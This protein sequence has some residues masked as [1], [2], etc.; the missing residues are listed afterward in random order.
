[1]T[2]TTTT[3]TPASSQ[4]HTGVIREK[5]HAKR[6]T[7][8]SFKGE[9]GISEQVEKSPRGGARPR[10]GKRKGTR[11]GAISVQPFTKKHGLGNKSGVHGAG[12]AMS[13]RAS[14]IRQKTWVNQTSTGYV[15]LEDLAYTLDYPAYSGD[16]Y[17]QVIRDSGRKWHPMPAE[18]LGKVRFEHNTDYITL[19][20]NGEVTMIRKCDGYIFPNANYNKNHDA[21][22]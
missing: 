15:P 4:T 2:K 22:Y 21:H 18:P 14:A 11:N 10:G 7:P 1:M 8:I 3:S 20:D 5:I 17:W 19:L 12:S 13:R 16:V 9:R 6:D